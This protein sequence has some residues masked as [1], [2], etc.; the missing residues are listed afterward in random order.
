MP[1]SILVVEDEP[2][3]QELVAYTCSSKA[4]PCAGLSRSARR[5]TRSTAVARPGAARLDAARQAGHRPAERPAH[6][7]RTRVMPVIMLTARGNEADRSSGSTPAPTTTSSSR[8]H[9]ASWCR[10]SGRCSRRAPAAQ[11][12]GAR[13]RPAYGGS[14]APRDFGRTVRRSRMGL[15]E[16]KLLKLLDQPSGARV[17]ARAIARQCLGRPRV[18]RGTHRR[19]SCVAPAQGAGAGRCASSWFRPCA[20]WATGCRPAPNSRYGSAG[21]GRGIATCGPL[22]AG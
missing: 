22:L 18:H 5:A 7:E 4:T 3:I 9:R 14:V 11:R 6:A 12:R 21:A 17:F 20:A 16:F 19:C 13:I 10:A 1:A 15:A 8:F 2:A